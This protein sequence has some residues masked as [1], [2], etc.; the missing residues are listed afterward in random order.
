MLCAKRTGIGLASP[1]ILLVLNACRGYSNK[2]SLSE[3]RRFLA[4]LWF[5]G[6]GVVLSV[7][8]HCSTVVALL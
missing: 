6:N 4:I 5:R 8:E 1:S 7:E 3:M 2:T